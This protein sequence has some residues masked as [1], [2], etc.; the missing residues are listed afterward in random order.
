MSDP[1]ANIR[2][3]WLLGEYRG[4]ARDGFLFHRFP[5]DMRWHDAELE[6]GD[7]AAAIAANVEPWI[8][9]SGGSRRFGDMAAAFRAGGLAE[10]NGV[11]ETGDRVSHVAERYR[12]GEILDPA[13]LVA[14]SSADQLVGVEGHTRLVA[15]LLADRPGPLTVIVG[16]GAGIDRWHWR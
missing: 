11:H 9:L 13:I 15:W 3:A 6:P 16:F 8:S 2:R 10:T 5:P 4:W 1:E 12:A 7:V 14:R